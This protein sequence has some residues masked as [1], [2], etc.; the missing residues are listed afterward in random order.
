ML[1]GEGVGQSKPMSRHVQVPILG[2]GT[3]VDSAISNLITYYNE[4]GLKT[5]YSCQGDEIPETALKNGG[6]SKMQCGNDYG[7]IMFTEL[8]MF[9]TFINRTEKLL[10]KGCQHP[11][12]GEVLAN[13]REA[14][15]YYFFKYPAW[16]FEIQYTSYPLVGGE[17][18]Y[19]AKIESEQ[20]RVLSSDEVAHVYEIAVERNYWRFTVRIPA[21]DLAALDEI[22]RSLA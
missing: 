5:Q 2:G 19:I 10:G 14:G 8:E 22:V 16:M 17:V 7:Y 6:P 11:R 15:D 4:N 20:K 18:E 9:T 1:G 13:L 21:E 3:T 12:A